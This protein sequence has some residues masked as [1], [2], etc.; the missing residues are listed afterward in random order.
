MS[1]KEGDLV[2]DFE[3]PTDDGG[4]IGA[5][6][7]RGKPFVIY[8]Y[9]KDD[10]PG[11]TKEAISFSCLKPQFDALGVRVI[12]VSKDDT[13]SHE[14]FRKKHD[15]SITLASDEEGRTIEAFGAW[16][17]KNMYGKKSM[18]IERST[19]L[20][21]ADGRIHK[22]WRKVKVPGHAEEVLEAAKALLAR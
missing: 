8:F 20:V 16:V 4:R 15:L 12:G 3:L 19:F 5:A 17:E 9:P 21:D 13:A 2:P 6:S 1:V 18:G 22:V 14:K 7:L 10:T 11:C